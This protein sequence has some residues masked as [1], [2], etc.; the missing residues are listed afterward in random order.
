MEMN[1]D[2]GVEE[3]HQVQVSFYKGVGALT[4]KVDGHSVLRTSRVGSSGLIKPWE[5]V[6]GSAEQHNVRVERH[7]ERLFGAFRSGR[8]YAYVDGQLV[9]QDVG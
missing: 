3:R 9:A 7:R 1:F 6:V 4:I 5:F 2:V 8:F